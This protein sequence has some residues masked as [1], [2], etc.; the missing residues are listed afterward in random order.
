MFTRHWEEKGKQVAK[1]LFH[2]RLTLLQQLLEK[3]AQGPWSYLLYCFAVF[4]PPASLIP[5]SVWLSRKHGNLMSEG[6]IRSPVGATHSWGNHGAVGLTFH[7]ENGDRSPPSDWC[8]KNFK[9][10]GARVKGLHRLCRAVQRLRI[11]GTLLYLNGGLREGC[12]R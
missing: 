9:D 11:T 7:L 5:I 4:K 1:Q 2:M 6:L 10:S 12:R 8:A 3:K